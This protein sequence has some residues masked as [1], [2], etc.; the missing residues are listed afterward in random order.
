MEARILAERNS[1][2]SRVIRRK[3]REDKDFIYA[4]LGGLTLCVAALYMSVA[5]P[6]VAPIIAP[7]FLDMRLAALGPAAGWKPAED[8]TVETRF[9]VPSESRLEKPTQVTRVGSTEKLETLFAGMD[10]SL[11]TAAY[12][13][14]EVPRVFLANMPWDLHTLS[15]TDTRK[16]LF[17]QTMLPL[18]LKANETILLERGQ[19]LALRAR[20]EAGRTPTAEEASWLN[21]LA[22][23]YGAES[24][25]FDKLLRRVD[26]I[27]PSLALAQAA[28]E[29]G[30]GTSRFVQQGNAVFG[31]YT[32]SEELGLIPVQREDGKTHY[33]RSYDHL[34]D[35]VRSYARNLNTHAAYLGF[36]KERANMRVGGQEIDGYKLAAKLASYS[37]R[38]QEYVTTIRD[39]IQANSFEPLDRARLR[40][41][42]FANLI[43]TGR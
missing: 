1:P 11:N 10:Y 29:S 28:E 20:T 18:I 31:Q 42:K 12:D 8:L 13:Q 16:L 3:G 6:K 30:W 21:D 25:D 23:R 35:G 34:L 14:V 7:K 39:L 19:L 27:P 17:V 26:I 24:T 4:A 43:S 22:E 37:E 40:G 38:G 32:F 2:K 5:L 33:I 41:G 36:R 9:A 15:S